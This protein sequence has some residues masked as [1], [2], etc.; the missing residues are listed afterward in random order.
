MP[1]EQIEYR[2]EGCDEMICQWIC[3]D[4]VDAPYLCPHGNKNV[5]W[6]EES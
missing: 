4:D 2:C 1:T 3:N 6:K 5:C